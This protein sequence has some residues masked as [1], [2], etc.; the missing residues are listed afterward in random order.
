MSYSQKAVPGRQEF[1][2]K[3]HK[4]LSWRFFHVALDGPKTELIFRCIDSQMAAA[5]GRQKFYAKL[6]NIL[7]WQYW[8]WRVTADSTKIQGIQ[9]NRPLR[10]VEIRRNLATIPLAKFLSTPSRVRTDL[11]GLSCFRSGRSE[12]RPSMIHDSAFFGY[13]FSNF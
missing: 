7:W 12:K 2:A 6:H 1:Y 4:I 10:A 9:G 13:F 3:L 5:L 8:S 11:S